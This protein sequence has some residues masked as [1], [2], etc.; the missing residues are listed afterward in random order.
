MG[1]K[2]LTSYKGKLCIY[3]TLYQ[4]LFSYVRES[5]DEYWPNKGWDH[6]SN[7]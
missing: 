5:F 2:Y 1:F 3:E 6:Y 7:L 4:L